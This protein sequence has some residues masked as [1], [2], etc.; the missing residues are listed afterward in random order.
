MLRSTITCKGTTYTGNCC[1]NSDC[2]GYCS[3]HV[4][5]ECII[6]SHCTVTDEVCDLSSN[7]DRTDNCNKCTKPC[8]YIH[9]KGANTRW[10]AYDCCQVGTATCST[11]STT[12]C[13]TC[14]ADDINT[15]DPQLWHT[16]NDRDCAA[17]CNAD[18]DLTISDRYPNLAA[19]SK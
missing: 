5:V 6:D 10:D 14:C 13:V 4:C 2:S 7:C 8:D 11:R 18:T 16:Q 17:V 15:H 12:Q 1:D 3:N 19:A 9:C